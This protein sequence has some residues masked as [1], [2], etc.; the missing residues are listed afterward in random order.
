MAL[1]DEYVAKI[2]P[3]AGR[4]CECE[5]CRRLRGIL[6]EMKTEIFNALRAE[7]DDDYHPLM[8]KVEERL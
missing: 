4:K 3:G 5:E 8:G 7:F 6:G 1:I 2:M